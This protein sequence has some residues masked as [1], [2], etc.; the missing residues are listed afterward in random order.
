MSGGF[1]LTH[2]LLN[3]FREKRG[4]L[5]RAAWRT[6][7]LHARLLVTRMLRRRLWNR[8]GLLVPMGIGLSPTADCNLSCEGCYAR[9]HSKEDE[10]PIESIE[11]FVR[12]AAASGVV[13]FVVSGGEP[14]LREDMLGLY[15]RNTRAFF[16]TVTNGTLIDERIARRLKRCGNVY[17]IISIEGTREQTDRRRGNGVYESA[18]NA[19]HV[20]RACGVMFGFSAMLTVENISCVGGA[21]FTEEMLDAGCT[22]GFFNEFVPMTEE[23]SSLLP[24][25]DDRREFA[26]RLAVLRREK[27][28]LLVHLPDDEYDETGRCMAVGNGAFHVNAQG[29]VEPCPFAHVARENIRD[30]SFRDILRSPFLAGI[31]NHPDALCRGEKGCALV[32]NA[33]TLED[34]A[35]RCGAFRTETVS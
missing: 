12:D 25:G 27:P 31:R 17:P 14:F 34:I 13:L 33:R 22:S 30:A 10:L 26:E 5:L 32:S 6:R 8:H 4:F 18:K 24:S 19:M 3:V 21:E 16:L 35:R 29:Y 11:A 20:L 7:K 1:G 9:F 15:E 28:I 2:L 23:E